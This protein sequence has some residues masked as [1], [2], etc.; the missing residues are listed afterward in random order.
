[1]ELSRLRQ[2]IGYLNRERY[3]L[4]EKMM[5]MEG[6]VQGSL[7]QMKRVCGSANC[8]CV[9]GE[10][11]TAWYLSRLVAGKTRL[12]YVGKIVPLRIQEQVEAYRNYQKGL[13]RIRKIDKEVPELLNEYRDRQVEEIE[14][15]GQD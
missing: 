4:L 3:K 10:K 13:A 5:K 1:M 11:H 7:Y 12:S 2:R 15:E 6:M 8:K 9:R 14:L